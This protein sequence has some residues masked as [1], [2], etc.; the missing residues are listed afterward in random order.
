MLVG[1]GG[2][3][4]GWTVEWPL[5]SVWLQSSLALLPDWTTTYCVCAGD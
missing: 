2:G 3:G 4:G 5:L 1:G